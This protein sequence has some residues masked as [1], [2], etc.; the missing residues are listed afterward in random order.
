M[1]EGNVD[2]LIIGAGIAGLTAAKVLQ[3]AGKSV[4]IIE[5][6]SSIG[7]RVKTDELDGFLLD[8]GFQ[9]LLTAY[10][11]A[12]R[13]LDYKALD[14]RSFEP[15]AILLT[16]KGISQIGDP[17]RQP[18]TLFK[19]LFSPAG[20]LADKIKMLS[21]KLKLTGKS[22]EEI[23]A[24]TEITTLGYLKDKGFSEGMIRLFFRPF[25]TGIFLENELKTSSRMFEFVF[26][27][28]SE[29]DAAIP[30]RGMSMIPKQL[31]K[32]LSWGELVLNEKVVSIDGNTVKTG[33]GNN[34][35]GKYILFTGDLP[36]L[37]LPMKDC[38][39]KPKSVI[40]MYFAAETP[41]F[42]RPLIALNT[43]S[44]KLV[45][46]IAVMDQVSSAYSINGQSLVSV[47]LIGDDEKNSSPKI[48][49]DVIKELKQWYPDAETWRHLKTYHIPYALPNDEQVTNDAGL[50]KL[51]L[52]EHWFICGDHLLNGSIN[53]AMKSGRLA[54]E[55]IINAMG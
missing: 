23:F 37:S 5:A 6:T 25:M 9:V 12:Q 18:S 17:L 15:G 55:A 51:Q 39:Q 13:F 14:L 35:K 47:S 38:D 30:S 21:L 3:S 20:S 52:D 24:E 1:T 53:A 10:P 4:K 46:N 31:A 28:F 33:T 22:I 7:G 50:T 42:T 34:Y 43:L 48:I 27:M 29:G 19:T 8:H 40:T 26:K 45:N 54:A 2:V 36:D 41:P 16:E 49:P 11:E 32:D 44:Q